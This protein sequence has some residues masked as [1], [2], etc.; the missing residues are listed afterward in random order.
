VHVFFLDAALSNGELVTVGGTEGHHGV[1]VRRVE[2]GERVELVNGRGGR[3]L[4]EVIAVAKRSFDVVVIDTTVE[5]RAQPH[6]TVVQ[7]LLKGADRSIEM[8]CEL[9]VDRIVPWRAE[10]SIVQWDDSRAGKGEE[11]WRLVAREAAKQSRQSFLPEI[12]ETANTGRVIEYLA[13]VDQAY[14]CDERVP[15]TDIGPVDVESLLVVVGPEGGL[16]DGELDAFRA[17]GARPLRLG[18]TVLR[19]STAGTVA[20]SVL[21]S[22][23]RR[24][25][26]APDWKD[27]T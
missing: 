11:K 8:M 22:R 7:A 12:A 17:A 6:V 5:H 1:S 27:A 13:E 9:G 19:G 16:T 14:V 10:R 23:T 24:W 26:Q 25:T 2:R 21:L 18:P 4:A 3:A 15:A 20:L